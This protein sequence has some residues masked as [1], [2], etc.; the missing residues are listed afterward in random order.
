MLVPIIVASTLEVMSTYLN[1]RKDVSTIVSYRS[2]DKME[3][4]D[5]VVAEE[6][7]SEDEE[8]SCPFLM[9]TSDYRGE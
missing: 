6:V 8:V 2:I 4:G 5:Q 7:V 9:N 3:A 1:S